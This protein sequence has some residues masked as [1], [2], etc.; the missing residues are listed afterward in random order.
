MSIRITNLT[1]RFGDHV[2][3]ENLNLELPA[4]QIVALTGRSGCGKTTLLRMIAGL[5]KDYT[6]T[7]AGIPDRISFMFQEDRLLPWYDA[8]RNLEY[9]LKDVMDKA[10]IAAAVES[11]IE[12]VGLKGHEHKKPDELS[13]GM[14]RR[15]AMARAFLYP[16]DLL[17]MDEPFKGFDVALTEELIAL[18]ERLY[19]GSGRTVLLVLHQPDIIERLGCAVVDVAA[20]AASARMQ[21]DQHQ[22]GP[23]E[24]AQ[25]E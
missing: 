17:I 16:A 7:I 23:V 3:F 1:K 10:A 11:M 8:R 5:D 21:R 12:A 6:G 13:G 9:V 24:N 2:L 22:L 15:V 20:L 14:Q 25:R 18:F 19:V 4:G